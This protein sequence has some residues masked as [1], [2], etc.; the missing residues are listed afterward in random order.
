M[1]AQTNTAVLPPPAPLRLR[2]LFVVAQV[3]S[4]DTLVSGCLFDSCY[5]GKKGGGLQQ[6]DTGSL[7]VV[8][9]AFLNNSVGVH[10][11]DSGE[12]IDAAVPAVGSGTRLG[13]VRRMLVLV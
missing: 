13:Q 2:V 11:D 5:A 3:E 9:S 8:T 1:S 7:S 6:S 12:F 10:S 4:T